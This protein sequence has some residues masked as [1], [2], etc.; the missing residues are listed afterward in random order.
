MRFFVDENVPLR[1]VDFIAAAMPEHVFEHIA[2]SEVA[3]LGTGDEE[4]YA[5]INDRFDTL[6]TG[7]RRQLQDHRPAM[8]GS[9]LHWIGIPPNPGQASRGINYLSSALLV[10]IPAFL[11]CVEESRRDEPV[12]VRLNGAGKRRSQI[13]QV[14]DPRTSRVVKESC[15]EAFFAADPSWEQAERARNAA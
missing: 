2:R 7:D 5:A 14:R 15:H 11:D 6:I 10:G 9:S 12:W 1:A 13:L 8:L 3:S 4:L